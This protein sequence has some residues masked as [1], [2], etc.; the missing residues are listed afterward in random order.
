MQARYYDPLIGRFYSNDPVG[1]KN[2]HNFNR[3][4]YANNNPYKYVDPDGNTAALA[5]CG[6]GP[7]G[8]GVGLAITGLT[9]LAASNSNDSIEVIESF[10]GISD[11]SDQ[12]GT[13]EEM[14]AFEEELR[15]N[16]I[17][18]KK[19]KTEVR[20][21]KPGI[22]VEDVQD[23]APGASRSDGRKNTE[24]G[25]TTGTHTSTK[26][27]GNPKTVDVN[28]PNRKPMKFRENK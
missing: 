11:R 1:F 24:E 17:Q 21:L 5:A 3:Y 15:E 25:G 6:A 10:G 13:S 23:S 14:D 9:I 8:C 22:S 19:G 26:T 4:T 12:A 2:V 20:V 7:V 18:E 28:R 16:S 27:E